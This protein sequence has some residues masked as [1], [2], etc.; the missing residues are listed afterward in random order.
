EPGFTCY[1]GQSFGR[2]CRLGRRCPELDSPTCYPIYP[3]LLWNQVW[4]AACC[5]SKH[6]S[7]QPGT[8]QE[9]THSEHQGEK[10]SCGSQLA[11]P[12]RM[13]LYVPVPLLPFGR[14]LDPSRVI[15]PGRNTKFFPRSGLCA[16]TS[17]TE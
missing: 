14:T 9:M 2:G 13:W 17:R 3:I 4:R 8:Q 1:L 11:E 6:S 16:A 7:L 15:S 12:R 10:V 5:L